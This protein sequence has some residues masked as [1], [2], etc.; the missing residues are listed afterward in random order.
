MIRKNNGYKIKDRYSS[1]EESK[2]IYINYSSDNSEYYYEDDE[3]QYG[4]FHLFLIYLKVS[5]LN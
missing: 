3:E 2:P 1:T 4:F 5:F